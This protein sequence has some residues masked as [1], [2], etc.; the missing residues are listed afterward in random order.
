M[1]TIYKY[2]LGIEGQITEIKDWII[3]ILSIQTQ[4]GWPVLWAIVDTEKE[5]E[6]PVQIYCCGTGWPLPDDYGHYLGT[7]ADDNGYI[8]HYFIDKQYIKE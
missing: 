6:E 5:E 7:A 8:W 3:E 2:S 1:K 4:D